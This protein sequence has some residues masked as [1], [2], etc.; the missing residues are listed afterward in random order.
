MSEP[1]QKSAIDKVKKFEKILHLMHKFDFQKINVDSEKITIFVSSFGQ[2]LSRALRSSTG[3]DGKSK[4]K[5]CLF[6]KRMFDEHF[7]I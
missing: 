6:Y 3:N 2:L 4:G 7:T 5:I 1:F